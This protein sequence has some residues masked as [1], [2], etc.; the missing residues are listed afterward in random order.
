MTESELRAEAYAAA[1][2]L[3]TLINS[4]ADVHSLWDAFGELEARLEALLEVK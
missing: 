1:L 3:A 4:G 2:A